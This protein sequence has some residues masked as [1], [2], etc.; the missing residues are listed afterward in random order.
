MKRHWQ[1]L[2][3]GLPDTGQ[4]SSKS[5]ETELVLKKQVVSDV[6]RK[7]KGIENRRKCGP[8]AKIQRL[9]LLLPFWSHG[10]HFS[11]FL[12]RHICSWSGSGECRR[13]SEKAGAGP[14]RAYAE[15]GWCC[16]WCSGVLGYMGNIR[17]YQS[18]IIQWEKGDAIIRIASKGR[19]VSYRSGSY[20]STTFRLV[21]SR[22]TRGLMN[23]LI[24]SLFAL[25]CDMVGASGIV[26]GCQNGGCRDRRAC[27]ACGLQRKWFRPIRNSVTYSSW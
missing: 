12:Q 19:V 23:P 27:G 3:T 15:E 10:K 24:S 17:Q 18:I 2:P 22:M 8:S 9:N 5:M 7:K 14:V 13:A 20:C 25:N 4:L 1:N 21:W 16:G 26:Y 6:Q 11:L